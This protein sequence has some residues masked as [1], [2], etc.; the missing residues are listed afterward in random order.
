MVDIPP[1]NDEFLL[2]FVIM[3][4]AKIKVFLESFKDAHWFAIATQISKCMGMEDEKC[5]YS[6]TK[7]EDLLK[8]LQESFKT[9]GE[10]FQLHRKLCYSVFVETFSPKKP[11][12]VVDV[13]PSNKKR[14]VEGTAEDKITEET[15][16]EDVENETETAMVREVKMDVG[17]ET[18]DVIVKDET[19]KKTDTTMVRVMIDVGEETKDVVTDEKKG[20]Q[21]ETIMVEVKI[22]VNEEQRM[23]LLMSRKESKLT[24]QW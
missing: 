9:K 21:T 7:L 14:K 4:R 16:D 22:D 23:W 1:I 8:Y 17:E 5:P 24:L 10:A 6:Y 11:V 3:V 13:E 19:G 15:E 18:R 2:K 20:K 12:D